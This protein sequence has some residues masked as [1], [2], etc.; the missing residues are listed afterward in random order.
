MFNA[1]VFPSLCVQSVRWIRFI[2]PGL[3]FLTV[4]QGLILQ[5]RGCNNS[6]LAD[7]MQIALICLN[8]SCQQRCMIHH[9]HGVVSQNTLFLCVLLS[10]F[11]KTSSSCFFVL[12]WCKAT[13]QLT[14]THEESRRKERETSKPKSRQ[15]TTSE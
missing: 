1:T 12:P 15:K 14:K 6:G 7:S 9:V 11:G 8:L 10:W 5:V 13:K 2:H 3:T 4:P